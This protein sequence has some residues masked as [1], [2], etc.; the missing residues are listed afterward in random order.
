MLST[1]IESR[2]LKARSKGAAITS[3]SI[4]AALIVGAAYATA[5]GAAAERP[6]ETEPR[7]H[8]VPTKTAQHSDDR[9]ASSPRIRS[10]PTLRRMPRPPTVLLD[11]SAPAP[12]IDL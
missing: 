1:L 7:I 10:A 5:A 2:S 11:I 8:W 4:H 3:A 6:P 9:A 12:N